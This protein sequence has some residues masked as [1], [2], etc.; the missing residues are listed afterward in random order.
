MPITI[1]ASGFTDV[2]D[3]NDPNNFINTPT[4]LLSNDSTQTYAVV[5]DFV[6]TQTT[7][8]Q[9]R[10][11]TSKYNENSNSRLYEGDT[12]GSE[13]DQGNLAET[14]RRADTTVGQQ[15]GSRQFIQAGYEYVH[16]EYRGD[17]RIVG[18]SAGQS[19]TTNDLWAQDRIQPFR[20]LLLTLGV[21]YQNNSSYGGHA[22]PKAGVVYRLN[23][24]FTL[25][26]AFGLGFRAP[27]LGELYYHLLHLEYGYQVI[28]NPTLTP[29]TSQ[30]YSFGGTF[31][32]R[33]LHM[34]VNFF[35]NNL[36]NLI[37]DVLVCDETIGQDCSGQALVAIMS[38]YGIPESFGYDTSGAALF[39][40]VNLNVDRAFTEGFDVNAR[41]QVTPY[42]HVYG[43]YT[44]LDAV[45]TVTDTWL[46]N[47]NR[48]QGHIT[49][50]Y[51]KPL[52][53]LVANVRADFFSKWPNGNDTGVVNTD[54]AYGYQTWNFYASK[55]IRHP[56][57]HS[58]VWLDR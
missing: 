52:W 4:D 32:S 39:T 19:V 36:R 47:R 31:D 10:F 17:N 16:D 13:F 51:S 18:G 22:V 43:A 57:W 23:D 34:S 6:P 54:Y 56:S 42:F 41:Y 33:R 9:A 3:P 44:Y 2:A 30:S 15:W 12:P 20:N 25:R 27:N 1:T 26:S 53:G 38:Q 28:G 11:Y 50:E 40:F 46:P 7:T 49:F 8:L 37:D 5:G 24:H 58:S 14:Y 55:S 29:E 21:R 35:R 48:H 45:D